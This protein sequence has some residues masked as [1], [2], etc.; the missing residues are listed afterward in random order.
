MTA[1]RSAKKRRRK[2]T[3]LLSLSD[4]PGS[5]IISA[6]VTR[7]LPDLVHGQPKITSR[8]RL[9][10]ALT[11]NFVARTVRDRRPGA[12][13]TCLDRRAYARSPSLVADSAARTDRTRRFSLPMLLGVCRQPESGQPGVA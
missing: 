10:R 7:S 5:T 13:G 1:L 12:D 8:A 3:E 4:W 11:P 2:Y 6:W 9:G